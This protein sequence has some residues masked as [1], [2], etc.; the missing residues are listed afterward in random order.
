[1]A[2]SADPAYA[3]AEMIRRQR[4]GAAVVMGALSPRTR[5]AQVAL[6][7][8]GDVDFLVA[9]DAIGMGLNMDVDHVAFASTRNS[10]DISTGLFMPPNWRKLPAAQAR[11]MND[12]TFGVTGD[13]T[14]LDEEAVSR[15]ESHRFEPLRLLQWRNPHLEFSSLAALMQSLQSD[16][17]SALYEP[18]PAHT[19]RRRS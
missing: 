17:P 16:R 10:T 7:Q 8:S 4:G 13:A 12:G 5:N 9:T 19:G 18:R 15:I 11:H 2:F 14:P 1:M 6:Y 3:I